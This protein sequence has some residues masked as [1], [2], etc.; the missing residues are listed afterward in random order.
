MSAF[1]ALN[2][3]S[4]HDQQYSGLIQQGHLLLSLYP[5][6]YVKPIL[7]EGVEKG[8]KLTT[9]FVSFTKTYEDKQQQQQQQ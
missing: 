5:C 4:Y 2:G 3:H 8:R 7:R 1:T 6:Y 9:F